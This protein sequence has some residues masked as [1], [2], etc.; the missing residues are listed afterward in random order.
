MIKRKKILSLVALAISLLILGTSCSSNGSGTGRQ[1]LSSVIPTDTIAET[2]APVTTSEP[3]D[4]PE[5][6]ISFVGCGDNII[7]YGNVREAELYGYETGRQY[8]FQHSYENIK[9]MI[10]EADIAFINQ[11][12]VMCGEGY[13]LSYY[14]NFNSP[15][16]V[17][18]DLLDTG[19]DIVNIA[20]NH[21]MD[22]G[23][24]GL[25]DTISFWRSTSAF[26]A[27]GY[28]TE[29]DFNSIRIYEEQ[30]INIAV[31][32]YTYGTNGMYPSNDS[33]VYVPYIDNDTIERQVKEAVT[34]ADLVL[35]SVH[36]GVENQ[37]QPNEEQTELAKIIAE[38]GADVIIGHHP[39][40]IQ[41]VEWLDTSDGRKVL[42]VYSLGNFM[43]EQAYDYNMVG[44]IIS[45]DIIKKGNETYI[46][47]PLFTPTLFYF[48]TSFYNNKIYFLEDVTEELAAS[49][50][51]S[52]YGNGT[53]LSTLIAY[54][55][56]TID[57]EFLP[58]YFK[59]N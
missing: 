8:N 7:Y 38:A 44:G 58:E 24:S 3:E 45:F 17:G 55:T 4:L 49:H 2:I 52:S 59:N 57:P 11:E 15:Q 39:H 20:N 40:V 42:C 26:L 21:M 53:S 33:N 29:E 31:L 32:S 19:Y 5:T 54:V 18:Y 6:R 50:G 28:N 1:A 47:S 27:G 46:D 34:L 56:N 30:G 14:P 16:D 10:S 9:G 23:S 36:W 25:E 12:T 48:D 41:P 43:A 22:M 13:D 51:I 37:M 35:V